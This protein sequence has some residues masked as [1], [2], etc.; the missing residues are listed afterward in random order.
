MTASVSDN[1]IYQARRAATV[2]DSVV[3]ST[4]HVNV[5]VKVRLVVGALIAGITLVDRATVLTHHYHP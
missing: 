2:A 5:P 1:A 4:R 3:A